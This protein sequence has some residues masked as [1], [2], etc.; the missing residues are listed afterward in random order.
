VNRNRK[1]PTFI[2]TTSEDK[3][4]LLRESKFFRKAIIS[5]FGVLEEN[6]N[7]QNFAYLKRS[8]KERKIII[9]GIPPI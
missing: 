7:R 3:Q 5:Y 4:V 1:Q 2:L 6:L 9:G 8:N